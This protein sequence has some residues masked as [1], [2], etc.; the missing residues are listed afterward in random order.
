L[1]FDHPKAEA[2]PESAADAHE[3]VPAYAPTTGM[4]VM[5]PAKVESSEKKVEMG[6]TSLSEGGARRFEGPCVKTVDV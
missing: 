6:L 2:A 5:R 3:T 1:G 4:L